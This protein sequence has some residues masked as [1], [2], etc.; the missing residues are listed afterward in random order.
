MNTDYN[1]GAPFLKNIATKTD[2]A[3]LKEFAGFRSDLVN[4]PVEILHPMLLVL[5]HP[6]INTN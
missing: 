1:M 5:Q 2:A 6:I 4:D 3:F